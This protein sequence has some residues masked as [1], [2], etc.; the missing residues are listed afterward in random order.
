MQIIKNLVAASLAA[1]LALAPVAG[2]AQEAQPQQA[3]QEA[4]LTWS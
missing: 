1:G 4:G 3:E 2:I